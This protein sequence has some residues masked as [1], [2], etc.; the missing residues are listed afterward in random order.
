VS[1]DVHSPTNA[2]PAAEGGDVPTY[3]APE[4]APPPPATA[5]SVS[6]ASEEPRPSALS[7]PEVL[8]GGAFAGGFIAAILLKRLAD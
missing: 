4:P 2:G 1:A 5:V 7:R 3:E 6:A 8:A